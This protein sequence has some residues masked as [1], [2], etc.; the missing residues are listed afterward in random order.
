MAS[1]ESV[2]SHEAVLSLKASEPVGPALAATVRLHES[3][4]S[5]TSL[6]ES[7]LAEDEASWLEWST[8]AAIS[9]TRT[10]AGS[11]GRTRLARSVGSRR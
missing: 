10:F 1:I 6:P 2:R 5:L 3:N 4:R 7:P 11:D 9:L 8:L